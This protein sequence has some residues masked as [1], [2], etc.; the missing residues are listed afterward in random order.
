MSIME[1]SNKGYN[2]PLEVKEGVNGATHQRFKAQG[3]Q[4]VYRKQENKSNSLF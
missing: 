1:Q 4:N 3:K 2:N